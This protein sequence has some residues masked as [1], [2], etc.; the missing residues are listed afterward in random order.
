MSGF[1]D[2]A[3]LTLREPWAAARRVLA[4][5]T[6][7]DILW[8]LLVLVAVIYVVVQGL[9]SFLIF[10]P[11]ALGG[12]PGQPSP[13]TELAIVLSS[14]VILVFVLHFSGRAFGGVGTFPASIVTVAW[15]NLVTTLAVPVLIPAMVF[16]PG[17]G[18]FLYLAVVALFIRALI[19]FVREMHGFDSLWTSAGVV[20]VCFVGIGFGMMIVLRMLGVEIPGAGNV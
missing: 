4:F 20:A 12:G 10:G 18:S 8:L 9:V 15:L 17:L 2:L 16:A 11:A 1:G 6:T 13:F 14:S 19:H 7:R 3:L 5:R